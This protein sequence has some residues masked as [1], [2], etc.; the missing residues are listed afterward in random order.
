MSVPGS[1]PDR[2]HAPMAAADDFERA[3]EAHRRDVVLLC[4]RFLG[5]LHDAEEAA[6]ETALRAW[7]GR[8]SFRGE[9]SVR[10]WLH[11]I[12]TRVCL[13]AL[14]RRARRV[15]PPDLRGPASASEAPEPPSSDVHWLEPLPDAFILEAAGEALDPAAR[16]SVRESVSLAFLAALQSLPARQRAVLL[17]RVVLGWTAAEPGATLGMT[18]SAANSALHRA[19]STIRARHHGPGAAG[20]GAEGPADPRVR[21]LLEA[22]MRA[23]EADDIDALVATLAAEVRLAMPPSPSWYSGRDAVV[24]LVGRWIVPQGPFRMRAT[25]ANGQP[26]ALLSVIGRDGIERPMGVHVLTMV[27]GRISV[28]DAFM[29]PEIASRFAD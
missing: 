16:Y 18:T 10:T 1:S 19:R 3:I 29:D 6:Q 14:E 20:M 13:D 11:R 27:A 8:F 24:E 25:S 22:Y 28:I 12:A 4:Y 15:Q 9:S 7:R 17:L 26:A 2:E 23:W 21:R 5:S